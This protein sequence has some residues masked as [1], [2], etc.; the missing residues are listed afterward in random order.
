MKRIF[1]MLLILTISAFVSAKITVS[2]PNKVYH[3]KEQIN[4]SNVLQVI[5]NSENWYWPASKLYDLDDKTP[6]KL[7]ERLLT[8]TK[9]NEFKELN[10]YI[11]SWNV[12]GRVARKIDYDLARLSPKSDLTF[13]STQNYHLVLSPRP[14]TIKVFG[15][16]SKALTLQFVNGSTVNDYVQ[17]VQRDTRANYGMVWVIQS[18][19]RVFKTGVDLFND[20]KRTLMPGSMIYIPF[21]QNLLN[22]SNKSFNVDVVE[23]AKHKIPEWAVQ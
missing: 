18:D 13:Y 5:G 4:L 11:S 23:L 3:V 12:A 1:L 22:I 10:E 14:S 9:D 6:D 21:K 15:A 16:V 19:G 20:D 2:T 8:F 7:K 17:Q